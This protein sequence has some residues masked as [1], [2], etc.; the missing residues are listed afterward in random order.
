M[1][2][3]LMTT[4]G[5]KL[6]VAT[7]GAGSRSRLGVKPSRTSRFWKPW[8]FPATVRLMAVLLAFFVVGRTGRL[9]AGDSAMANGSD[10]RFYMRPRVEGGF[11][12]DRAVALI[13]IGAGIVAL[14]MVAGDALF[15]TGGSI[16]IAAGGV[17]W[18]WLGIPKP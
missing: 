3:A 15:L 4:G 14:G 16:S 7:S 17:W 11:L 12:R 10:R 6:A 1:R 5:E 13:V 9:R 8:I 18:L 2:N